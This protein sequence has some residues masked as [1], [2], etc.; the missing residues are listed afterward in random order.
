MSC[1]ENLRGLLPSSM[2]DWPGKICSVLFLA[3]CNFRCPYCHNPEL[4]KAGEDAD[5]IAWDGIADYLVERKGW[6][7]GVSITG[8]EPTIHD[9]VPRLCEGLRDLGMAV[10]LD[11][12]G[13]HPRLLAEMLSRGLVDFVAMDLKTSL[14]RYPEVV[15]R[16]VDPRSIGES[17]DAIIRSGVEHEF[18]CTV[19]PGLVGLE[20][21]ESL[22][23]RAEGARMLVLQQ[24]RSDITL[25]P[26]YT[27]AEGYP[28]ET[29]LE[30]AQRLNRLVPAQVRGLVGTSY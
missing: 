15:R 11:T 22:A 28:E 20:D 3:G 16:P 5:N 12:N 18:R 14:E 13:S 21:L 8:G 19:V 4:L 29:I 6:I 17:V 7:D 25:D 2:L 30:W 10:K 23:R 24:F 27:G 9:D 26:A 1:F